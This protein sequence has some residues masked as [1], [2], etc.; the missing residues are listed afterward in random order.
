M[1]FKTSLQSCL[2]ARL[3]DL[4]RLSILLF[5]I[6]GTEGIGVNWGTQSSHQLPPSIVVRMLKDNNFDKVKLF[7]TAESTLKALAGTDIEVMVAIPNN[8]LIQLQ[9]ANA[10]LTWVGDHVKRYIFD[11]GVNI[12]YVAV[13]NEPYLTSYNGTYVPLTF[14]ALQNVQNALNRLNLGNTIKTTVPMNADVLTDSGTNMPSQGKFRPDIA[15]QMLQIVSFLNQNGC[16]FTIN[17]YPFISY[18]S[19]PGFP[20]NYAFFGSSVAQITDGSRIYTNTFDASYDT[21]V[22]A[23]SSAGFPNMP[24]IVGEIGWATDGVRPASTPQNAQRFNQGFLDHVSSNAGTPLRPNVPIQY[25][26]FGLLDEDAKDIA[27]GLFERHWGIF[28]FDGNA[29]Y[30]LTIPGATANGN[31]GTLVNAK[32]VVHLP[33]RWCV[34]NKDA[35][36]A[37]LADPVNFACSNA[38][39]TQLL[40]G[41]SCNGL[42]TIGNASYAFNQYFQIQ[43]QKSGSCSFNGLASITHDDPSTD[44]CKFIIQID[45][46]ASSAFPVAVVSIATVFIS[47]LFVMLAIP[48]M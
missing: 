45:V 9:D 14:P 27:P 35:D 21:L 5:T 37:K 15:S 22:Q 48:M 7:D 33:T 40:Y 6:Q 25:Y 43:N 20:E 26:L 42:D 17:I 18:S 36:P 30:A 13:A 12:K 31:S 32:G 39:C 4:V 11:G 16:P 2:S 1:V 24:I 47:S 10:A 8:Q 23:L 38:D 46:T 44:T 3:T 41:A 34:A 29:K 28:T 19:T